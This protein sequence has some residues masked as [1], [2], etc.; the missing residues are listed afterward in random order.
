MI[1]ILVKNFVENFPNLRGKSSW[2][3]FVA[4]VHGNEQ[5]T[6]TMVIDHGILPWKFT[7]VIYHG[8]IPWLITMV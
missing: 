6:F 2:H 5:R 4:Q 3:K 7:M 1:E 8:K